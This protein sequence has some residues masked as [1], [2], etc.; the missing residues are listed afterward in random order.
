M[1]EKPQLIV[2]AAA[3]ENV[4]RALADLDAVERLHKTG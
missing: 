3:Y 1:A 4:E 2:Y